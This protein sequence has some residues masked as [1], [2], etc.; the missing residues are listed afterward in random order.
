MGVV[1][2]RCSQLSVVASSTCPF[3]R[4]LEEACPS[5]GN[6]SGDLFGQQSGHRG[7]ATKLS[8]GPSKSSN[9]RAYLVMVWRASAVGTEVAVNWVAAVSLVGVDLEVALCE[10]EVVLGGKS[11]QGVFAAGLELASLAMAEDVSG[12]VLWELNAPLNSAAVAVTS[13]VRH[14]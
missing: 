6:P 10:L 2:E 11:V 4:S 13:V 12:S 7:H 3:R 5:S 9:Q 8:A 1:L 14:V